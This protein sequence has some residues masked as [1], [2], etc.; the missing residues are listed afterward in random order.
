MDENGVLYLREREGEEM[1]QYFKNPSLKKLIISPSVVKIG[2]FAFSKSGDLTPGVPFCECMNLEE[3]VIEEG[4]SI[5]KMYETSFQW[6]DNIKRIIVQ[7]CEPKE[8]KKL[9]FTRCLVEEIIVIGVKEFFCF[10]SGIFDMRNVNKIYIDDSI[11]NISGRWFI[12][13]RP[14]EVYI[15]EEFHEEMKK[16]VN[17]AEFVEDWL[18]KGPLLK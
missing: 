6:S 3:I 5:K 12:N 7:K 9:L 18:Y 4:C 16:H 13:W 11:E 8:L 14:V 15:K 10:S 1:K 2:Q 17:Q